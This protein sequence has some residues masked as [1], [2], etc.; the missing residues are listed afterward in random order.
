M[1]KQVFGNEPIDDILKKI[2]RDLPRIASLAGV[3]MVVSKWEIA[4]QKP[5]A[6]YVDVTWEMVNVFEPDEKT[7]QVIKDLLKHEPVPSE[8]LDPLGRDEPP[9]RPKAPERAP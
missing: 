7:I 6:K 4:Y 5:P 3:D 8:E 2:E 9:P 1:N